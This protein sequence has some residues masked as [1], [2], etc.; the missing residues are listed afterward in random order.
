MGNIIRN[1]LTIFIL[2]AAAVLVL[3]AFFQPAPANNQSAVSSSQVLSSD[4]VYYDFGAVSM[5]NGKIEHEFK[6][7]NTTAEKIDIDKMYTSCMCTVVSF[8]KGDVKK[9]PFGMPGHGFVPPLNQS[10]EPNEEAIVKVIFDPAAH[11]PAGIG[12]IQRAI[13][14]EGGGSALIELQISA[15]VTP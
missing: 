15:T 2:L 11:G 9:G 4:S 14:L 10:L 13:Y 6:V 7:K 8:I 12:K 3:A 1:P 5:A